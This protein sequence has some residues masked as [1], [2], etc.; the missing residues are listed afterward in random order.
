MIEIIEIDIELC[1]GCAYCE[2]ICPVRGFKVE[3]L[4][5]FLNK[6]NKCRRC[7]NNCPVNAIRATWR[8]S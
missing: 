8:D 5:H 4:S 2:I 7:I 6:C 1:V 3:G